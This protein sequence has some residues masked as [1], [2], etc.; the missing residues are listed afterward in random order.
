MCGGLYYSHNGQERRVS[1]PTPS[2]MLPVQTRNGSITLLPW[3]R[4]QHQAGELPLGGWAR[5]E[6]IYAGRW[7]RWFPVPV[8]LPIKCFMELDIE[9][10]ECWYELAKGQ[11]IQGLIAKEKHERRLYIVTVEPELENAI[12]TRWPRIMCG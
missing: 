2:A 10:H 1:F 8:K 11:W 9:D 4:R 12:H 7:D 5:L 6:G 3:G